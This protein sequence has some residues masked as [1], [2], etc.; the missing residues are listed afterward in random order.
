VASSVRKSIEDGILALL[1]PMKPTQLKGLKAFNGDVEQS[2][3]DIDR[4]LGGQTPGALVQTS[5]A[6]YDEGGGSLSAAQASKSI[7]V[8]I[9]VVSG[10]LRSREENVRDDV[11]GGSSGAYFLLEQ[12]E[13]RLIGKSPAPT[14]G[15][16]AL[17]P[18]EERV[19]LRRPDASV[20]RSRWSTTVLAVPT[21]PSA[22]PLTMID[23]LHFLP[24]DETVLTTGTGDSLAFAAGSVTLTDTGATFTAAYIGAWIEITGST[25]PGNNGRFPVTAVPA[26]TQITF[27]NPIGVTQAAYTGQWIL[28]VGP[29][30]HAIVT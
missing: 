30:L 2:L 11:A 23:T 22:E 13:K 1:G 14:I 25:S 19:L 5:D 17:M 6:T 28:R 21:A 3:D 18:T 20:W 27:T 29:I 7:S 16:G 8:D 4:L 10:S 12:I 9:L 15:V 24:E 26:A